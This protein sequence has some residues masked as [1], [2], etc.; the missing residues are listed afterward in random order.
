MAVDTRY[1][2][3][4]SPSTLHRIRAT[5][6]SAL[7]AA[8]RDGL[9]RDNPARFVELPTPAGPNRRR[10]PT[11]ESTPGAAANHARQWRCGRPGNS[12]RSSTSSARTG[13][14]RCGG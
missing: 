1:G 9:L 6:R 2:R 11:I 8:I 10:G 13:Y 7:N 14:T 3:P 5:L 12:P 4:I